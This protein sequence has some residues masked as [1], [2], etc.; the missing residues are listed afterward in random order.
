MDKGDRPIACHIRQY[1]LL[2]SS[3]LSF[4]FVICVGTPTAAEGIN[5]G[6]LELGGAVRANVLNKSW[7]TRQRLPQEAVEFDTLRGRL[8]YERGPWRASA[9]YRFYY[10][11][12]IERDTHFLH[13][14]W[15][16]HEAGENGFVKAGV[17]QVPFGALPFAS[18]SFFLSLAYYVGL[19][20]DYDL[21]VTVQWDE[22]PW[23]FDVG[24]F[25]QDEGDGFGD[26]VDSARYS[27]DIVATD[28]TGNGERHQG[29][30]RASYALDHAGNAS[31]EV[32]LSLEY[33]RVPNDI[34][35]HSGDRWAAAAHY[36][37]NFGRWGV[38]LETLAYDINPENPGGQS[39]QLIEM[40]AYDF[41][42]KVSATGNI[43]TAALSYNLPVERSFLQSVT[44]YNDYSLFFKPKTGFATSQLNVTGAA[45][46]FDGPL[47]VYVDL[48]VGRN[49][50]WIGP[51]FGTA[52]GTGGNDA[53]H[54]RFNINFGL[55]F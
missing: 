51:S 46:N 14:A 43:N 26:S 34:T 37:G 48:A 11:V 16:G 31:S 18:N 24:Y 53:W 9:Q 5:I 1:H 38:K 13:H 55:Y 28:E 35:G 29:N 52:F 8:D 47:F 22:G 4:W 40:G 39:Q 44:F 20:D 33:G 45:F 10:Y 23:R 19:E 15:L 49:N 27:Y 3:L 25:P 36:V 6:N 17:T 42:Y 32:G 30:L 21:G 2:L 7:E 54:Q 50:A 12:E 41:P